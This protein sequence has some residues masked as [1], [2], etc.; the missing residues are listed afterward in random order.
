M[1]QSFQESWGYSRPV[2]FHREG[3]LAKK[4][5]QHKCRRVFVW[6]EHAGQQRHSGHL[7]LKALTRTHPLEYWVGRGWVHLETADQ[8]PSIGSVHQL[9]M[10][11]QRCVKS[12]TEAASS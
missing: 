3:D 12:K 9:E 11:V 1:Q 4:K 5:A 8:A 2:T 6:G 10:Q 7:H